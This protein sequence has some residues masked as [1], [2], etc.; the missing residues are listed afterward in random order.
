MTKG[1]FIGDFEPAAF[2]TQDF[3]VSWRIH[4]KG[5]HWETHYHKEATEINLLIK[6]S[7]TIQNQHLTSGDI[8]ILDPEEIA[9]PVFL[10][11]CE[12]LCIKTPSV[13]DDKYIVK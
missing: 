4:P 3:E 7:M 1:W 11:D 5:E 12:V 13:P 10:E 6:G 8:F 2:K 9:D